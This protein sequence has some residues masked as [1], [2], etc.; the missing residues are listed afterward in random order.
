M[1]EG[2][3]ISSGGSECFSTVKGEGMLPPSPVLL[4]DGWNAHV[5][6]GAGQPSWAMR[7]QPR[8]QDGGGVQWKGLGPRA[9]RSPGPSTQIFHD[10]SKFYL[11]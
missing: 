1:W 11:V 2:S 8:V 6:T 3:Y 4:P 5:M 7:Q 9:P 10:R